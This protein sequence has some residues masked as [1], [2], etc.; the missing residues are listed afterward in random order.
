MSSVRRKAQL[1]DTLLE[2]QGLRKYFPVLGGLLKRKVG[3]VKAVDGIDFRVEKGTTLGIVGESGS[4]KTTVGKTIARLYAPTSGSIIF[5]GTDIGKLADGAF[6]SFRPRIQMV[7]QD[8]SSSLNFRRKIEDMLLD[9]LRANKIG[10]PSERH[11]KVLDLLELVGL[12]QDNYARYPHMLSGGQRQRISVARAI[13]SNPDLVV[14]DEPTSALDV[15]VQAQIIEL[16]QKIQR[17]FGISYV[18]I[19][20]NIALVMNVAREVLVMYL[21]KVMEKGPAD[22]VLTNPKHPYTIA[23]L[24]STPT[25]T[26]QEASILPEKI[27]LVG[28]TPSPTEVPAGCRFAP[29]CPHRMPICEQEPDFFKVGQQEVRCWLHSESV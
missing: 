24:S 19:S 29:R 9:P 8:P 23:L 2:V 3:E 5:N 7:F 10:T 22:Q 20:H 17:E 15:S 26:D 14:L 13:I 1:T 11:R 27:P 18:F 21:G 28:E 6:R 25:I 16:L 4:G 12:P